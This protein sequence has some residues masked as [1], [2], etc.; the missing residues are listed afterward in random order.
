MERF[1]CHCHIFN[2]LTVGWKAI[3]E[4][5]ND[6]VDMLTDDSGKVIPMNAVSSSNR[7]KLK[8]KIRK[9]VQLIKIFTGDSEK[10]FDMLDKNYNRK[11]KLF[12][13]MF[14]GDFLLDSDNDIYFQNINQLI[15]DVRSGE[16]KSNPN[17]NASPSLLQNLLSVG[18][19]D[20]RVLFDFL[21]KLSA[22]IDKHKPDSYKDGFTIQYEQIVELSKNPKYKDRLVPFLGVDP[23][24]SNIK[25]YLSQVGAGKLFAGVKVYPPNGFS[26]FDKVLV[27]PD[28][29]FEFCCKNG[30]PI[31][32][33][34]SYGGFATPAMSIDVNGLIIPKGETEP[35]PYNGKYTFTLGLKNGFTEMVRE[36]AGVLNDPLIWEK[37]LEKYNNLILVLAHFGSGNDDWQNNILRL[38]KKYPNFYTDISCMS[39]VPTLQKVKEIYDNNP[40]IQDKILYGSDYFLDMFFNDSF[41]QYLNRIKDTLKKPMFDKISSENPSKYMAKWYKTQNC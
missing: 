24:R 7:K 16:Y 37:V 20:S 35:K 3:M 13:L 6:A 10:I 17:V 5:L 29:I 27:G 28:S 26:P 15:A 12:P 18:N 21:Q 25:S 34:C 14:D 31:V 39:D 41:V 40:D 8:I 9:L 19:D 33:H 4:E 2:I 22:H 1:D 30:I 38:L 32:S 11:Y 36:R 23:R